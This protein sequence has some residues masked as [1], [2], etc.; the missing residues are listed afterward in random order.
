MDRQIPR[1]DPA[2]RQFL[3]LAN[4]VDEVWPPREDLSPLLR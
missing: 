4:A 3:A 2:E 1:L